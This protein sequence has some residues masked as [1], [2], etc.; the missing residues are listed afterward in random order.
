MVRDDNAKAVW[1]EAVKELVHDD[2]KAI[3]LERGRPQTLRLSMLYALL[4]GSPII[5]LEHLKAALAVWHYCEAS[6]K[7]LFGGSSSATA[8]AKDKPPDELPPHAKLLS[9]IRSRK[10]GV[11][12]TDA[13]ALFNRHRKAEDIDADFRLLEDGFIVPMNGRWYAK[14]SFK[15]GGVAEM[16]NAVEPLADGEERISEPQNETPF[17]DE[18]PTPDAFLAGLMRIC[19]EAERGLL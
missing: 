15:G 17:S 12:K 11:T 2:E 1:K 9:L 8:T 7:S 5:H 10:E 14:E 16:I 19:E 3:A 13:H 4:D 18:A 6:A